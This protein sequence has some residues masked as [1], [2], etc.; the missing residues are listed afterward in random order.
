MKVW[1][2]GLAHVFEGMDGMAFAVLIYQS[3]ARDIGRKRIDNEH[4]PKALEHS[5]SV[6]EHRRGLNGRKG[7]SKVN[8]LTIRWDAAEPMI[9]IGKGILDVLELEESRI[10]KSE[11]LACANDFPIAISNLGL[12]G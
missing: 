5:R 4:V 10:G 6:S 3:I 7:I 8:A 11:I 9:I 1:G 12:M 2:I